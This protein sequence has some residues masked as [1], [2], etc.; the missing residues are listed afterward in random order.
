MSNQAKH[1][2]GKGSALIWIL[3]WLAGVIGIA[4]TGLN[5]AVPRFEQKLQLA[6]QESISSFNGEPLSVSN[7]GRQ[8]T[9]SGEVGSEKEKLSLLAAANSTLGVANVRSQITIVPASS[10]SNTST[11]DDSVF[12]S[13]EADS[14]PSS[15]Q[16]AQSPS[17]PSEDDIKPPL[18]QAPEAALPPNPEEI[19]VVAADVT[20]IDANSAM[21]EPS[22][23]IKVF[24]NILSIEGT[25]SNSDDT[26][27]LV[28]NALDSFNLDVVSNGLTLTSKV[29]SAKWLEPL[30]GIMPLMSTMSNAQIG[31]EN[32]QLTLEGIA[33]TREIHDAIINE[34]LASIGDFSLIERINVEGESE[35][36]DEPTLILTASAAESDSL[37]QA[38]TDADEQARLA[39]EAAALVKAQR[40][41]RLAAE[42]AAKAVATEQAR[43][44]A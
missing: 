29:S 15:I 30:Q 43:L 37:N 18:P 17:L 42:A 2:K 41:E 9:L 26:S 10:K 20:S 16:L 23:N 35:G 31:V 40:E 6:V 13:T 1:F 33:P 8:I 28:K 22:I 32:Q 25:M 36:S 5:Y 21:Q 4:G 44:A 38:A 7:V 12:V 11:I 24:G 14:A 39:A 34:A 3:V 27:S 19:E